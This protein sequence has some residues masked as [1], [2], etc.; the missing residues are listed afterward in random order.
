M[1]SRYHFIFNLCS[2]QEHS[3]PLRKGKRTTGGCER[4]A[5]SN[6]HVN[7]YTVRNLPQQRKKIDIYR[8]ASIS[9][10]W[11]VLWLHSILKFLRFLPVT[12]RIKT[13]PFIMGC[14]VQSGFWLHQVISKDLLGQSGW[15]KLKQ[16]NY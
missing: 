14:S 11:L 3:C 12:N 9:N 1:G 13:L 5:A 4:T 2:K 7:W 8:T 15:L 16:P 10:I 6:H